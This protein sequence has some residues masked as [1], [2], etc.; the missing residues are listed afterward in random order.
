M[1]FKAIKK[2]RLKIY[3][4]TLIAQTP[5]INPTKLFLS[6]QEIRKIIQKSFF[7]WFAFCSQFDLR[8]SYKSDV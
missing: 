6:S 5:K 8:R 7:D 2:K 3:E 1:T 4:T